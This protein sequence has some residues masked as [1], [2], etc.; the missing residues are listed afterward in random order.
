MVWRKERGTTGKGKGSIKIE[1]KKESITLKEAEFYLGI[2]VDETLLL[3]LGEK[4]I[5]RCGITKLEDK[6]EI[7]LEWI[8]IYEKFQ[9]KHYLRPALLAI[10]DYYHVDTLILDAND[11]LVGIYEHLGATKTS[12]DDFRE[13]YSLS[14]SAETLRNAKITPLFN[15]DKSKERAGVSGYD[16]SKKLVE[17][18]MGQGNCYLPVEDN[19]WHEYQLVDKDGEIIV[20]S[21]CFEN[22]NKAKEAAYRQYPG[23]EFDIIDLTEKW[24][25]ELASSYTKRIKELHPAFKVSNIILDMSELYLSRSPEDWYTFIPFE[26]KGVKWVYRETAG[27]DWIE[28]ITGK[29]K[30][31]TEGMNYVKGGR[32]GR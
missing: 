29:E 15:G 27:G 30:V 4:E 13:M 18:H 5:G 19:I 10:S 25:V 11:E 32:R 3:M 14:L 16:K 26:Y 6:K 2:T 8:E 21:S 7:Y 22:I 28:K 31:K 12:Y 24:Y 20:E 23:V 1:T 9:G 17:I